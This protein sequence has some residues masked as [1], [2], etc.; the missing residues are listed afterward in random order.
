MKGLKWVGF[1][2]LWGFLL[3]FQHLVCFDMFNT[4]YGYLHLLAL[5]LAAGQGVLLWANRKRPSLLLACGLAYS[6]IAVLKIPITFALFL[7]GGW[8]THMTCLLL[9]IAGA[10]W[11]FLL[12]RS[13]KIQVV[14]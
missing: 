2:L 7:T 9:D 5:A 13:R 8:Q 1:L 10:A 14:C 4:N 6:A 12:L 11:C 3:F